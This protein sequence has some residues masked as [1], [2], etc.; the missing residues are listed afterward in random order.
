MAKRKNLRGGHLGYAVEEHGRLFR[1]LMEHSEL[2]VASGQRNLDKPGVDDYRRCHEALK[3]FAAASHQ[4]GVAWGSL[5][6]S[7]SPSGY[8]IRYDEVDGA[9]ERLHRNLERKCFRTHTR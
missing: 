3:R 4:L 2:L 1:D 9:A 6:A 7:G 5:T 8:R